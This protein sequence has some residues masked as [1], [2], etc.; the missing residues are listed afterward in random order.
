MTTARV[1]EH[2]ISSWERVGVLEAESV[3]ADCIIA[4]L[5]HEVG[6]YE[7]EVKRL[8]A[9]V[10]YWKAWVDGYASKCRGYEQEV[11]RLKGENECW[12]NTTDAEFERRAAAEQSLE[13]I[14]GP[15]RGAFE[16]TNELRAWIEANWQE[17]ECG[18]CMRVSFL[19]LCDHL[20]KE[21]EQDEGYEC[22][23][24]AEPCNCTNPK[25]PVCEPGEGEQP[26]GGHPIPLCIHDRPVNRI[27]WRCGRFEDTA[28]N[29]AR[30]TASEGVAIPEDIE[31][32]VREVLEKYFCLPVKGYRID[33]EGRD[34]F[35][36]DIMAVVK[37]RDLPPD[38]T[39][40]HP[41][42]P[43]PDITLTV[44]GGE[45]EWVAAGEVHD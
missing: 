5:R 1:E 26:K 24:L 21:G 40:T 17:W 31:A 23:C 19:A 29:T 12:E 3:G 11:E 4:D 10:E 36:S 35:I 2:P 6:M 41:V 22:T 7:Q 20:D 38:E 45:E 9:E 18:A 43:M 27:C 30:A 15:L 8:L 42:G 33:L 14:V 16:D 28:D 39:V 37:P 44:T 25:C 34:E 13:A 32:K